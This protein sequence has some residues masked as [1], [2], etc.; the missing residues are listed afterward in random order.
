MTNNKMWEREP[1]NKLLGRGG[2]THLRKS[3]NN[4]EV[5]LA[6]LAPHSPASPASHRLA[7][8]MHL[9]RDGAEKHL[10]DLPT[11][12][13]SPAK[14]KGGNHT[15]GTGIIPCNADAF[16]DDASNSKEDEDE[17]YSPTSA[18]KIVR[19]PLPKK[20]DAKVTLDSNYSAFLC[21]STF[22]IKRFIC[23]HLPVYSGEEMVQFGANFQNQLPFNSSAK[24]ATRKKS[25]LMH[26][27]P[28]SCH[29][30]V[31]L[32]VTPTSF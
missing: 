14:K 25:A 21:P 31:D 7:G 30:K 4:K 28:A 3:D 8:K 18:Y 27:A 26:Q 5:A 16:A 20:R 23:G 13:Y 9:F 11:R 22:D 32:D 10:S 1:K 15:R 29:C 17:D 12:G 6:L 2:L 24:H 19:T